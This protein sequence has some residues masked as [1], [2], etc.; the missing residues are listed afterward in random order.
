MLRDTLQTL[1][2]CYGPSGSEHAVAD[3]VRELLSG[4]VDSMKTDAL[5]NLIVEKFSADD[6]A[7]TIMIAAHM[8]HI[9]LVVTNIEKDG[10][11]RVSAIG[12]I[13]PRL[14]S[15]RKVVFA[16]GTP[17]VCAIEPNKK[18]PGAQP[19][20]NDVFIDIGAESREEAEKLVTIG[21]VAVYAPDFTQLGRHKVASPAMD[22][23]CACA[24]LVELLMY[25]DNQKHNIVGVFTTQEEVGLRGATVAAFTVQ[26]DIG[27]ALDVTGWGDTPEV[28][29]PAVK[30]GA[31]PA[32][33]IMDR[34]MIAT[35]SVREKLFEAAD[36]AGV[37][38]QR[39]VLAYGGTDGGAIQLSRGG[40]P[41]GTLSIPCRYVHSANEVIDMRDME[42]ALKVLLQF[43]D[44]A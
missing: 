28:D 24:L 39:E 42:G 35:P 32:V 1:L 5:G 43:V 29:L 19:S 10:F 12:G 6:N 17:G 21:D 7:K 2:S 23:R 9:G 22:D 27:L 33:K 34:S 31:G 16:D 44:L 41:T 38:V 20:L 15:G 3:K 40:V 14:V 36:M 25:A 18:N 8:D 13:G 30:L 4:H 26:P 37:A 11:L